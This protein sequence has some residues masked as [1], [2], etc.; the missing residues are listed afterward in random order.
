MEELLKNGPK[1]YTNFSPWNPVK[2]TKR[3]ELFNSEEVEG[4]FEL[5]VCAWK[6]GSHRKYKGGLLKAVNVFKKNM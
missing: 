1:P 4:M 5:K 6:N 3:A 2:I